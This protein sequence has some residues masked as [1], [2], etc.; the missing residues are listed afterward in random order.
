MKTRLAAD[1]AWLALPG[2]H[3]LRCMDA[4]FPPQLEHIPQ[5]PAALFVVGDA[6]VLLYPQVA[7]RRR[8]RGERQQG[9]PTPRTLPCPGHAGFA[10]TSGL[11]DGIDGAA[12]VAAWMRAPVPWR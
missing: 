1:L 3:L 5:P 9:W 7:V 2:H 11:A 6:S 8:A 4:D 10:I 12:H